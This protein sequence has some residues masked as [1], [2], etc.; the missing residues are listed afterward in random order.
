MSKSIFTALPKKPRATEWE[1]HRTISL[2]SHATKIL[3]KI[4]MKRARN[5]IKPEIDVTQCGFVK[6]KEL[7][8]PYLS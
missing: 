1:L 5:K 7:S 6:E 2:M 3:L 4:I 8:I